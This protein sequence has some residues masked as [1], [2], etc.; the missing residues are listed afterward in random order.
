MAISGSSCTAS[1]CST[2]YSSPYRQ[3]SNDA[4]INL[5]E[6]KNSP[7]QTTEYVFR[8]ELLEE[9]TAQNGFRA[10]KEQTIDPLNQAAIERYEQNSIVEQAQ[11]KEI[12][13]GAIVDAYA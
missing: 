7:K 8:G 3:L 13:P 10:K 12:G 6:E 11:F 1:N 4:E 5:N 2:A 9:A